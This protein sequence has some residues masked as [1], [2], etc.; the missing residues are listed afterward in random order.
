[1]GFHPQLRAS[2]QW[3]ESLCLLPSQRAPLEPSTN[4]QLPG[5]PSAVEFHPSSPEPAEQ[6]AAA[7]QLAWQLS[8]LEVAGEMP[9]VPGCNHQM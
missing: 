1:M 5:G 6:R 4:A 2:L 7:Q 9:L 3:E 8:L